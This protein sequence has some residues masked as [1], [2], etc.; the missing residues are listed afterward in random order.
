MAKT[1]SDR[2]DRHTRTHPRTRSMPHLTFLCLGP[3]A[4]L[5]L[6]DSPGSQHRPISSFFQNNL[7]ATSGIRINGPTDNGQTKSDHV[8]HRLRLLRIRQ[9]QADDQNDNRNTMINR[10]RMRTQDIFRF[11]MQSQ[12]RSR[13]LIPFIQRLQALRLAGTSSVSRTPCFPAV[14]A[15]AWALATVE[16]GKGVVLV[17]PYAIFLAKTF[18]TA[19]IACLCSAATLLDAA[20]R[21]S[22]LRLGMDEILGR[23]EQPQPGDRVKPLQATQ[24]QRWSAPHEDHVRL[25]SEAITDLDDALPGGNHLRRSSS[26]GGHRMPDNISRPSRSF[27]G[28]DCDDGRAAMGYCSS[29]R[30]FGIPHCTA[31]D[32]VRTRTLCELSSCL[33]TGKR[34]SSRSPRSPNGTLVPFALLL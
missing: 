33:S 8:F 16:D 17:G 9:Y 30:A 3:F 31:Q 18:N 2:T 28:V 23:L 15:W 22:N 7:E 27:P 11:D 13:Y 4:Q 19:H 21:S 1:D 6:I 12:I 34:M 29:I 32:M 24:T 20:S 25:I 5:T 10:P 14:L 26:L